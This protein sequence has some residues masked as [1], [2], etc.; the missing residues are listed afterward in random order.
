MES[1]AQGPREE[2][3]R[4]MLRLLSEAG[5]AAGELDLSDV[6]HLIEMAILDVA[7]RWEGLDPES[8]NDAK[9]EM[10]AKTRLRQACE[11]RQ[12][13]TVYR[14]DDWKAGPQRSPYIPGGP[15]LVE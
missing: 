10:V 8:T 11:N 3:F 12:G 2:T 9:L 5:Q 6:G 7:L 13:A 4:R 1:I 14:M 15:K